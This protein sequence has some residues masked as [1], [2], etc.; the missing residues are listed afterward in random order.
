LGEDRGKREGVWDGHV[1]T[2]LFK[3]DNQQKPIVDHKKFSS[4]L[5]GSL[6]GKGVWGRMDT[7]ICML[8]AFAVLISYI[9]IQNKNLKNISFMGFQVKPRF[10]SWL[11]L[12][13]LKVPSNDY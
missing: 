5:C 6:D 9:P 11:C 1:Y 3:M 13:W 8:S 12:L 2:A 7:R 4:M 10:R